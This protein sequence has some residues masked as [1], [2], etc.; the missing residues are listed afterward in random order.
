MPFLRAASADVAVEARSFRPGEDQDAGVL[1][2]HSPAVS[3]PCWQA[4]RVAAGERHSTAVEL[5][6][7]LTIEH[8]EQLAGQFV[9]MHR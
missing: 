5:K 4:R 8:R 9:P 7:E 1:G 3:S 2:S 6:A